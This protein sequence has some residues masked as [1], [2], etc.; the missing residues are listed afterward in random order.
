MTNKSRKQL[1]EYMKLPYTIVL[2]RDDEGDVIAKIKEFDGCIADGQDE[3]EALGNLERVKE[4]WIEA[5][6]SGGRP[7][8]LPE[9]E[10]DLPSGKWLQRVPRSLHKKAVDRA[11]AEGVSLNQYVTSVLADA[12][13]QRL[14]VG[15]KP[16]PNVEAVLGSVSAG[17]Y[18]SGSSRTR[19]QIVPSSNSRGRELPRESVD[20]PSSIEFAASQLPFYGGSD[21]RHPLHLRKASG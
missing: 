7:V 19:L 9:E 3:M 11:E 20:L 13:G 1:L 14:G 15:S 12:I 17:A 6:L 21:E 5:C 4:M 18:A 16:A 8:P 10:S 2:R